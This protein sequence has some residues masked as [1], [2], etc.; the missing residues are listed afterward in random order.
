MELSRRLQAVA[1]LVTVG[2][3]VADIGTDHAYVPIYLMQERRAVFAIAMDV[4][5]GPL[6]KAKEH[7]DRSSLNDK[8]ELRLSDGF[9][10]LDPFEADT[11]VLAGMGGPLIIR[12]LEEYQETTLSLKECILQPQSEIAKVRAF[13]IEEGFLFIREDMVKDDGKYY[14]MIKVAVPHDHTVRHKAKSQAAVSAWDE[15]ELRY[16]K[17]LLEMK[18]PVLKEYLDREFAIRQ[19]IL[20]RLEGKTGAAIEKRREELGEELKYI[21]KGKD[22]YAV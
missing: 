2:H 9:E 1:S 10:K 5:E 3:R 11:A 15:T 12:I 13:L 19:Q 21:R 16:G 17:L 8:I 7:V 14:P 6:K 4:N 20:K 22:Y 18:H